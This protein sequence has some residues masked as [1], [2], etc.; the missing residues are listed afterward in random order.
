MDIAALSIA[1]AQQQVKVDANLA[2]MGNVKQLIE[3]QGQQLVEMLERSTQATV[4]HP[5]LGNKIDVSI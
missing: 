4:P 5:S 2:V 3:Q 1:M